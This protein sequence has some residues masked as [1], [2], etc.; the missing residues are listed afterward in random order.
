MQTHAMMQSP[1][2]P[3]CAT[4]HPLVFAKD[5]RRLYWQCSECDLVFADPSSWPSRSEEH[6]EYD[7]HEN[8]VNDPGYNRFLARMVAP[9]CERIP[10]PGRILDFGCGP[11]PALAQQ[12]SEVGFSVSLYDTFYQPNADALNHSYDCIVMTE[13]IEHLHDPKSLL[14]T[15]WQQVGHGGCLAIMTQRVISSAAFKTWPYKNDPTHVCFYT[16]KTFHELAARLGAARVEF[17]GRDMVFF[18]KA[19]R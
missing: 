1:L 15:L 16:E 10:A 9:I 7:L 4:T 11:A 3:L 13:V 5:K 14:P 17:I 6:S 8:N 19:P 2:C 12:L 18:T